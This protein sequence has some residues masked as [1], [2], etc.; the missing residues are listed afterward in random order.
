[1][2]FLEIFNLAKVESLGDEIN[3]ASADPNPLNNVVVESTLI[4]EFV[5]L[6]DLVIIKSDSPDPVLVDATLTYVLFVSNA[7]PD[8][9]TDVTITDTLPTSV[10]FISVT[11]G[12]PAPIGNLFTCN[13]GDLDVGEFTQV[14]ILVKPTESGTI[15]NVAQVAANEH[16]PNSSNNI[17]PQTTTVQP[18]ITP[19]PDDDGEPQGIDL[20]VNKFVSPNP[21]EVGDETTFTIIVGNLGAFS[22]PATLIDTLPSGVEFISASLDECSLVNGQVICNLASVPS[23]LEGE[24]ITVDIV[25]RATQTGTLPNLALIQ[26]SS[27]DP[28]TA[29]NVAIVVLEVFDSSSPPPTNPPPTNP[30]PTNPGDVGDSNGSGN[31]GCTLA[32]GKVQTGNSAI[33]F[34][35]LLLP[36]FVFGI[37]TLKRKK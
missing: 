15:L 13:I 16:D 32:A 8:P 19:P 27:N 11:N 5:P 10:D 31:S 2:E 35:I 20:F 36:L 34:A 25:V 6:A 26:G 21:I 30:P 17:S 14:T 29:N 22:I 28:D 1:M 37:R 24:V 33:N 18:R 3:Q 4:G 7:G 12:C 9:A 23:I